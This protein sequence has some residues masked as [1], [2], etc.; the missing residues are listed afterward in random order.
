MNKRQKILL[1]LLIWYFF[2][3]Y[4]NTINLEFSKWKEPLTYSFTVVGALVFYINY[5]FLF[6]RFL[7]KSKYLYWIIGV[8]L[9]MIV[10]AGAR[11]LVEEVIY[12][13]TIGIHNYFGD[14]TAFFYITDNLHFMVNY[15][16]ISVLVSAVEEWLQN[17]QEKNELALQSK[18][19]ELSFLKSQINPHFLFNSLNNIYTLAYKK[20]DNAPDAILKLSG[21]MRYMLEESQGHQVLLQREIT[22]MEDYIALQQLRFK[23]GT[24]FTMQVHGDTGAQRI[25]PL[26]LI[27]F[28]E[29]IFK[30]GDVMDEQQPARVDLII[31]G[32]ELVFRGENTIKLQHKD[33]VGGIG[34]QNVKRRLDLLYP[35]KY[36][37]Q[38]TEKENRYYTTLKLQLA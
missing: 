12:P 26:L 21:I 38:V 13:R 37:L 25:A 14:F 8:V 1:H 16:S 35:G 5:L 9:S 6:P 4:D 17:R 19:A 10:G 34:Q 7:K 18:T 23:S 32:N 3:F 15:V 30:H 24:N 33:A 2:L 27:G 28:I 22:Y 31:N 36:D 29:N 11:Y 20:S